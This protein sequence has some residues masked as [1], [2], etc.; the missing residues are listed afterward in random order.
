MRN[1]TVQYQGLHHRHDHQ[2]LCSLTW[3][4]SGESVQGA[5][6]MVGVASAACPV[7]LWS[8]GSPGDWWPG[9]NV[10]AAADICQ[11]EHRWPHAAP[12]TASR[13]ETLSPFHFI[14]NTISVG[15]YQ[16]APTITAHTQGIRRHAHCQQQD[17]HQLIAPSLIAYVATLLFKPSNFT[18]VQILENGKNFI[19]YLYMILLLSLLIYLKQILTYKIHINRSSL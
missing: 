6:H 3:Q 10:V 7:W 17:H 19:I 11:V 5:G 14:V 1:I 13:G 18:N 16:H 8:Y 2:D 9:S 12:D 15:W 4:G